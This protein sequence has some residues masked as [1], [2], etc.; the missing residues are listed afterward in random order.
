MKQATDI[1]LFALPCGIVI[2]IL[3]PVVVYLEIPRPKLK[4]HTVLKYSKLGLYNKKKYSQNK[5]GI[6]GTFIEWFVL[7][8]EM[9]K[10]EVCVISL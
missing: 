5:F 8:F 1:N 3:Y 6:S 2:V 9:S 7:Q 4:L 10:K